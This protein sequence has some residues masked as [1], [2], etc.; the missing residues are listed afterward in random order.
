MTI[1]TFLKETTIY[2]VVLELSQE[3]T[4]I[5]F[6]SIYLFIYIYIYHRVIRREIK[7]F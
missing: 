2:K 4:R 3:A 5:V 7:K 6:K 1:E